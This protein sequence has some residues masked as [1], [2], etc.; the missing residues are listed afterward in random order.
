MKN[1]L[2]LTL[3]LSLISFFSFA[4]TTIH[5][6]SED[7]HEHSNYK[8]EF[9]IANAPVYFV[10]EK[11]FG[12]GIHLHYIHNF[13]NPGFGLGL[14]VEKVFG[15]YPHNTIG[16]IGAY[17]PVE[18][19]GLNLAPSLTWEDFDSDPM[20]ALHFETTYDVIEIKNIDIGPAFEVGWESE[21][22]HLSLGIHICYCF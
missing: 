6:Q 14:G 20:F 17:R 2:F 18:R 3:L 16:V 7:D 5:S 9:A 22:I 12:Y 21:G 11:A 13:S 1:N 15:K 10:N 19:W 8:N 4:Q